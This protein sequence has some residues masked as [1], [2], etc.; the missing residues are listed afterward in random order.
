MIPPRKKGVITKTA[1]SA[2]IPVNLKAKLINIM[3]K[4]NKSYSQVV[5]E[6][7]TNYIKGKL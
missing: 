3:E 5:T 2:S 7:I 1:L 4:E 6:A